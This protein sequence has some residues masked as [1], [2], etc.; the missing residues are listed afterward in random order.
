MINP[1]TNDAPETALSAAQPAE[2]PN[3]S[4]AQ[5]VESSSGRNI[6]P[7]VFSPPRLGIIHLL[8]WVGVTAV[9]MKVMTWAGLLKLFPEDFPEW[10]RIFSTANGLV[11]MATIAAGIVGTCVIA[12]ARYRGYGGRLQAGH[13]MVINKTVA[14]T[15]FMGISILTLLNIAWFQTL[16][17]AIYFHIFGL[18][19][20]SISAVIQYLILTL[21]IVAAIRTREPL[22]WKATLG[23]LAVYWIQGAMWQLLSMVSFHLFNFPLGS[24]PQ[25]PITTSLTILVMAAV[26]VF[27]LT[28]HAKR[29]WLHWLGIAMLFITSIS[30]VAESVVFLLFSIRTQ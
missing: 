29:D 3:T 27:D 25:F 22:A 6:P 14:M 28:R 17:G 12:H 21:W 19:I 13:W 1:T 30:L 15:S 9:L 10:M 7:E 18:R 8:A 24:F 23:F 16:E 26:V 4:S 11:H 2:E 5:N 20:F